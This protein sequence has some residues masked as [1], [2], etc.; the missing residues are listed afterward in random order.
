MLAQITRE[1]KI[2]NSVDG[3]RRRLG[4]SG[5]RAQFGRDHDFQQGCRVAD[6]SGDGDER[7]GDE[8]MFLGQKIQAVTHAVEL[9]NFVQDWMRRHGPRL[10]SSLRRENF[11]WADLAQGT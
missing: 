7:V 6:A 3:S 11:R 2:P 5:E 10:S 1:K 9:L 4:W 8:G